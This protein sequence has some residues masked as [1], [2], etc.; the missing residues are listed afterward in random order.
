[1][2][3]FVYF[4]IPI[5][6]IL[7]AC[8][9]TNT[10]RSDYTSEYKEDEASEGTVVEGKFNLSTYRPEIDT[11]RTYSNA[12]EEI[13]V[14]KIVAANEELIQMTIYLSGA[15]TTQVYRWTEDEIVLIYEDS[16]LSNHSE[17]ILDDVPTTSAVET[18]FNLKGDADWE[19][20]DTNQTL[21]V[22]YGAYRDV[23][24]ARKVTDEVEGA[25]TIH[26]RYYAPGLGLVKETYEVKGD[27]GYS[28]GAELE[29]VE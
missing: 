9:N 18:V 29:K 2:R 21:N 24:V 13:Y 6:F 10:P 7:V 23:I 28:D 5:M 11:V 17:D 8:T 14:H 27:R 15:P 19:L 1:M 4:I 20:V 22:P 25:E 16:T 12:G 3:A 26:T